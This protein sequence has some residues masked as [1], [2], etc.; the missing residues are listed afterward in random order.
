MFKVRDILE[1]NLME[2][3]YGKIFLDHPSRYAKGNTFLS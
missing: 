3:D 2:N 1:K